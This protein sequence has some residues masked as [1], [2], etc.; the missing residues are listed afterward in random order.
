M[1]CSCLSW[2]HR[3]IFQGKAHP[4]SRL[5]VRSPYFTQRKL[6][7]PPNVICLC[8]ILMEGTI[9]PTCNTHPQAFSFLSLLL[10]PGDAKQWFFE[11]K[12]HYFSVL[13][14]LKL[15][16]FSAKIWHPTSV[17]HT[18]SSLFWCCPA[19]FFCGQDGKMLLEQQVLS[20]AMGVVSPALLLLHRTKWM[21]WNTGIAQT[22]VDIHHFILT[23]ASFVTNIKQFS[24]QAEEWA[25]LLLLMKVCINAGS[26]DP[27]TISKRIL[28]FLSSFF[29]FFCLNSPFLTHPSTTLKAA[30]KA[31]NH[32][33]PKCC[34]SCL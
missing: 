33:F 34:L 17:T 16:Y 24:K 7:S 18:Q 25:V 32:L 4:V 31:V 11:K 6:S 26:Y 27:K 8:C 14:S 15:K 28:S 30:S 22:Y 3:F 21:P 2:V 10:F 23:I 29:Y 5:A 12:S 20:R 19:F 1:L 13:S 9:N